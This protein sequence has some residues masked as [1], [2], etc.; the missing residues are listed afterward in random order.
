MLEQLVV[1]RPAQQVVRCPNT[2]YRTNQYPC[3]T[4]T[5]RTARY[6][7]RTVTTTTYYPAQQPAAY[8]PAQQPAAYYPSQQPA[9]YPQQ[10]NAVGVQQVQKPTATPQSA[11]PS[12]QSQDRQQYTVQQPMYYN[13]TMHNGPVQV[14]YNSA[15][16]PYYSE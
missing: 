16:Q 4:A 1:S 8:Y 6:P 15:G 3:T 7:Y 9:A 10:P 12:Y 14:L 13:P 11:P 2:T 5:V